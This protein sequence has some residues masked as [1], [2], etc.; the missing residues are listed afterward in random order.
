MGVLMTPEEPPNHAFVRTGQHWPYTFWER[1]D[2][3]TRDYDYDLVETGRHWWDCSYEDGGEEGP[4]TW[5]YILTRS[6]PLS[7]HLRPIPG[8]THDTL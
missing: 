3:A 8:L 6:M 1:D 7:V 5:E 4:V 2:Q